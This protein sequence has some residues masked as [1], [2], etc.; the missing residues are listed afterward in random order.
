[1]RLLLTR[2]RQ[3]SEALA[4]TL[5]RCGHE[6]LIEPLLSIEPLKNVKIESGM[7]QAVIVTSVNGAR[8]FS[9]HVEA[10][11]FAQVPIYAVGSATADALDQFQVV[12]A[13]HEGVAALSARICR[14]LT[15]DAGP[16]LYVHGVHVAGNLTAELEGSGYAVK[17]ITIYEAVGKKTFSPAAIEAFSNTLIDGVVLFSPRTAAV[18]SKLAA[19]SGLTEKLIHVTFYCLSQN[20]SDSI[21]LHHRSAQRRVVI[22]AAPSQESLISEINKG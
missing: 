10:P 8:A 3:E 7:P 18:F 12:H 21:Q 20:V 4:Q 13:G 1:M 11:R 5:T 22:A 15:P 17:Q 6:T 19:T 2:P 9:A 14:E 16:L